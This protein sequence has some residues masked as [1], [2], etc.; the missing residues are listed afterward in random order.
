MKLNTDR[1]N[2]FYQA[3]LDKSF[4]QAAD[5]LCIT[6]SALSQRVLKLEQELGTNLLI[7]S[8]EG[9]GLT[10]QGKALFDY[11]SDLQAREQDV[12]NQVTGRSAIANG[13]IR[14]GAFSSVMRSVI[15]PSLLP[16]INSPHQLRVEFFSR[17]LRELPQLLLSGEVDF[18]VLDAEVP[19]QRLQF[20]L[21][22]QETLVHIRNKAITHQP[23]PPIFLDHD[24]H[25]VTTYNFFEAQG[26]PDFEFD[27][28]F[29]DDVYGLIDGVR[30]GF[31]EAVVSR[32]IIKD[33]EEFEIIRYNKAVTSP[34]ILCYVKNRYL[35][36]LQQQVIEH[37][38]QNVPHYL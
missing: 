29:Y 4:C 2:A 1:L 34:V 24:A 17:E 33:D 18:I 38:K 32:H 12:L 20:D 25:D 3:A 16:L 14:V 11:V 30:L 15:M 13:I 8:P 7:R 35:S 9:I 10:E 22:G 6:Q 31:G 36:V 27:R 28:C 26:L 23:D 21:L 19:D 37:L 5:T